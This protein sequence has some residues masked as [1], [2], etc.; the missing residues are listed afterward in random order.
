MLSPTIFFIGI[1]SIIASFKVF[2]TI[3]IMTQGGPM[4]ASNTLVYYI[5]ETGF[6]FF[7]MGLSS[8]A[9]V[10]LFVIIAILTFIYFKLMAKRV[11]Y[12]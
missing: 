8:A 2:E 1:T 10:I 4:N 12:N 11:Y 9:G 5:Y 6:T 7:N 3:S